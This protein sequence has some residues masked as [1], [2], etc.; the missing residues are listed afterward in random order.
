MANVLA[1]EADLD[2]DQ[3]VIKAKKTPSYQPWLNTSN[4][5]LFEYANK[6][7]KNGDKSLEESL[8]VSI[9]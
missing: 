9:I 4:D 6:L 1:V 5:E 8:I 2:K 7:Y 3:A